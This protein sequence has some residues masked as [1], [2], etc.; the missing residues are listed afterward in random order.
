MHYKKI[1]QTRGLPD[2]QCRLRWIQEWAS[3]AS[4]S[5]VSTSSSTIPHSPGTEPHSHRGWPNWSCIVFRP[6]QEPLS[7]R[8]LKITP[9]AM[10][11]M[12]SAKI[13]KAGSKIFTLISFDNFIGPSTFRIRRSGSF[14]L[15]RPDPPACGEL[16]AASGAGRTGNILY[17]RA[18]GGYPDSFPVLPGG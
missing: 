5:S 14:P 16:P 3:T 2:E 11:T 7:R 17:L 9:T 12:T 10:P 15:R 6:P 4:F 18:Q 13:T 1:R 8:L